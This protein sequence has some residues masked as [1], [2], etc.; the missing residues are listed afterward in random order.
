MLIT[1]KDD[2]QYRQLMQKHQGNVDVVQHD[3]DEHKDDHNNN[4]NNYTTTHNKPNRKVEEQRGHMRTTL[5]AMKQGMGGKPGGLTSQLDQ[6]MMELM[7]TSMDV[8]KFYSPPRIIDMAKTMV[9]RTIW[10]M[11]LTTQDSDGRA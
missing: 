1:L 6:T 4:N 7:I 10:S 3:D 9:L 11:D 8:A 5:H 2:S